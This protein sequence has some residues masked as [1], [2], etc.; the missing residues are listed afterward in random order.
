LRENINEKADNILNRLNYNKE[1]PFNPEG[2]SFDYVQETE[3][4]EGSKMCESCG[5]EMNEGENCEECGAGY[6]KGNLNELGDDTELDERLYGNQRRIDRNKN[7][8]LDSEDFKML[9]NKKTRKNIEEY[10]MGDDKIESVK[11]YGDFSTDSP[12]ITPKNLSRSRVKNV[13]DKY[14]RKVSKE[15]NDYE[16]EQEEGTLYEIQIERPNKFN[17]NKMVKE[18]ALFTESEVI[19]MVERIINEENKKFNAG[20]Q[21][22]GYTEYERVHKKDKKE[23]EDYFKLLAKKMKDY[24][25]DSTKGEYKEN[26]TNFPE[27]NYTLDKNAKAKKYT[28]SEAVDDYNDAFSY[29]GQTNLRYVI[30]PKDEWME[31]NLKGSSKTGNAQVDKDGNAL[32]NVVPSKTGEKFYKNYEENLYGDEQANASYKR[33]TQPVDIAGEHTQKG[34]LKSKRGKKT[35][36]SVLNKVDEGFNDKESQKLT[37]EFDRM[38]LLMGYT[39]KTQ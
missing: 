32:G 6:G 19:E 16:S 37:E 21:P 39:D 36:Q 29:P 24:L 14:Q 8:R 13:G 25:K 28:P 27:S 4:M 20:R 33:Q 1:A 35:A 17:K 3:H 11:S 12:N 30:K 18:S 26:P 5:G 34:S 9:R 31:A 15:F 22:K 38:K 2:S 23:E 10:S 7:G